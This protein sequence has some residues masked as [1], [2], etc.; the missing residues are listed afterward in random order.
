MKN[1][2][3]YLFIILFLSTTLISFSSS[4]ANTIG[5]I[6]AMEMEKI[7]LIREWIQIFAG[8]VTLLTLPVTAYNIKNKFFNKNKKDSQDIKREY[9]ESICK[10]YKKIDLSLVNQRFS[11]IA[12]ESKEIITLPRIYQEMEAY[13]CY[14]KT[15]NY[16][17]YIHDKNDREKLLTSLSKINKKTILILGEPGSGKS[18]FI[19]NLALCIARSNLGERD[20]QLPREYFKTP[21]V[22]VNLRQSSFYMKDKKEYEN[23][24][25]FSIKQEIRSL[26]GDSN[27]LDTWNV[28]KDDLLKNGTILLDGID[29]IPENKGMRLELLEDLDEFLSELGVNSRVL[30]TSRPYAFN[31]DFSY[32]L[33]N[34]YCLEL[35]PMN[36][37]QINEFIKNWYVLI[38]SKNNEL[39]LDKSERLY[40]E[41]LNNEYLLEPARNPLIL[42]LIISLHSA[43]NIF[44]HSRSELYKEAIS[45]MLERWA[46]RAYNENPE[47]PLEDY[48]HRALLET[49]NSKKSALQKIALRANKEENLHIS[50]LIIKGIFSDSLPNNCNANNLLDFIRYRSGILKAGIDNSFEFYHRSFQDYLAALEIT[51]MDDWQDK[52]YNFLYNDNIEWWRNVFLLLVS[53]KVSGNSKPDA[54]S[55]LLQ[56]IP[57][58]VDLENIEI[59]LLVGEAYIEQKIILDG[60]SSNQ[61][62]K[63]TATLISK[64]AI[65][66]DSKENYPII[67]RDKAGKILGEIGDPRE[68][69]TYIKINS[70]LIPDIKWEL[71]PEGILHMGVKDDEVGFIDEKPFHS[72][73]MNE[74]YVSRYPI[75]NA[76]YNCFIE[77]G[78]YKNE[79]Y[80]RFSADSIRWLNGKE[81]NL[82]SLDDD[83][84]LKGLH[85]EWLINDTMRSQP[86][87]WNYRQWKNPNHPVVGVSWYEALAFCHWLNSTG[88]YEKLEIS[89]PSE[90][91][92]EYLAR[93]NKLLKYSWGNERNSNEGNYVDSN[94]NHTSSVGLF[95]PG[96]AHN[97]IS[98]YDITGN[99]WEWTLSQWGDS[100]KKPDYVYCKWDEQNNLRND[101]TKNSL[102]IIRGGA[103]GFNDKEIRCPIRKKI[104]PINRNYA[105]GFR[106]SAKIKN[107]I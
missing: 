76:Q 4:I 84:K 58:N 56:H 26:T 80:W 38:E 49:E 99:I 43:Y 90:D 92:W 62:N 27:Y 95:S 2:L 79:E 23:I 9:Y 88:Y 63:L 105:T 69:V 82:S 86:W 54:V 60:Y 91:E 83:K 28:L 3:I 30:I 25:L 21:V 22:R 32:W 55:L 67:F 12:R 73:T 11:N 101:V 51:E 100:V 44:P 103:W 107:N 47:Y 24:I 52:I 50:D 39:S 66:L 98:V 96:I 57:E 87:L 104:H 42:T 64:L 19:N 48:E 40:T 10:N 34:T 35:Q 78:G 33:D 37:D 97:S 41:L 89:L 5:I 106:V 74:Y 94:I 71:I 16:D 14:K 13:P 61:Y 36:D 8:F 68:G 18:F 93:G 70:I 1:K 59:L 45:L 15:N 29:E 46:N 81:I 102:R 77:S 85:E 53:I 20:T 72:L 31:G 17:N 65:I 75:T 6:L 7:S